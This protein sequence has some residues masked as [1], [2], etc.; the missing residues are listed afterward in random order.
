MLKYAKI[1][2]EDTKECEVGLGTNTEFYKS[3]GM[4]EM[5]VDQA[6]NG[7]WYLSDHMPEKPE[8]VIIGEK[9]AECHQYLQETD[10]IWNVIREGDAS[11]EDYADVL[12]KRKE[13]RTY[14]REHE[15]KE[16]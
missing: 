6:Y 12:A 15:N 8:A 3:I 7:N 13:A 9:V 2:N 11:E 10:Y 14:I 5:D 1:I 4:T 16:E